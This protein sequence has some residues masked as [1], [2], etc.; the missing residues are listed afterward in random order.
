L[1]EGDAAHA[2]LASL[3]CGDLLARPA[4]DC[5]SVP[6]T[7]LARWS[8]RPYAVALVLGGMMLAFAPFMP[9][10]VLD[11][12]SRSLPCWLMAHRLPAAMPRWC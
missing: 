5:P 7:L 3:R 10:I 9:R 2:R 8:N 1:P 12:H 6:L 4:A 11:P